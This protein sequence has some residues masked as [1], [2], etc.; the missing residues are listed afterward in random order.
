MKMKQDI[1]VVFQI[2]INAKIKPFV[3]NVQ[4]N[5]CQMKIIL[6]VLKK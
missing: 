5:I 2:V 1:I 3:K 4:I 6:N